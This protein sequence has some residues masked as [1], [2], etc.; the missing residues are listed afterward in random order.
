MSLVV[1]FSSIR[2][3]TNMNLQEDIPSFNKEIMKKIREEVM[4]KLTTRQVMT[5]EVRQALK[6]GHTIPLLREV[7]LKL[8]QQSQES[9]DTLHLKCQ[10]DPLIHQEV[11]IIITNQDTR[12]PENHIRV[13]DIPRDTKRRVGHSQLRNMTPIPQ[14]NQTLEEAALQEGIPTNR[15]CHFER[16]EAEAKIMLY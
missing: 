12:T 16:V 10:E 3:M 6:R 5:Q 1:L 7:I 15:I 8:D 11:I 2:D 4:R 14:L 13:V 9:K